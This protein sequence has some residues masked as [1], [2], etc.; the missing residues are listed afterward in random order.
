[1]T[2]QGQDTRQDASAFPRWRVGTR[3]DTS[4]IW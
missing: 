4:L 2:W 1:V 3:L